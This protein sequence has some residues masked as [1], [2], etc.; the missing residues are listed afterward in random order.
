MKRSFPRAG[1]GREN[2]E[3]GCEGARFA[4][5]GGKGWRI[6]GSGLTPT[7]RCSGSW[8]T[9]SPP[10]GPQ[11]AGGGGKRRPRVPPDRRATPADAAAARKRS[12]AT[13]SIAQK[14]PPRPSPSY[15][16][17]EYAPRN[18][19]LR[20][21]EQRLPLRAISGFAPSRR[22]RTS[23]AMP[24]RCEATSSAT[25]NAEPA[26]AAKAVPGIRQPGRD[27]PSGPA[28]WPLGPTR[29]VVGSW[30]RGRDARGRPRARSTDV[31]MVPT[32][33]SP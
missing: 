4:S 26:A 11:R 5:E 1:V 30:E 19:P 33:M 28:R 31:R 21:N 17:P 20:P 32:R 7:K 24:P 22:A 27:R 23:P 18:A 6:A 9:G 13:I 14:R 3:V 12:P 15:P 29:Q 8:C 25:A 16:R 10:D 2:G